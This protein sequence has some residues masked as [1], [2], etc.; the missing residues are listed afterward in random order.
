MPYGF[1]SIPY[2]TAQPLKKTVMNQTKKQPFGGSYKPSQ[3]V[4]PTITPNLVL[5]SVHPSH[6]KSLG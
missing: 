4:Y 6:K 2:N 1:T 3:T 5:V